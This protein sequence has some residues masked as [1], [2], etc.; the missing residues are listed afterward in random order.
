MLRAW[1]GYSEIEGEGM[2]SDA[3]YV[4]DNEGKMRRMLRNRDMQ[5]KN[6]RRTVRADMH[7]AARQ[8]QSKN[9]LG[10]EPQT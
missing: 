3:F 8:A 6:I 5:R 4:D 10:M 9:D 2:N 7:E 1:Y